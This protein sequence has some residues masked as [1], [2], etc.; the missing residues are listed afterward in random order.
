MRVITLTL[1][2]IRN[3][4]TSNI[5]DLHYL[6]L[7]NYCESI[8]FIPN[9]TLLFELPHHSH[10]TSSNFRRF[11]KT[12]LLVKSTLDYYSSGTNLPNPNT[13]RCRSLCH[14]VR[15]LV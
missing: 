12:L 4:S 2:Y 14:K 9:R 10:V 15:F 11:E 6:K 7:I 5:R 8:M 13:T 3:E 1:V